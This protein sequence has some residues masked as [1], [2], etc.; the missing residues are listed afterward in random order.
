M[1]TEMDIQVTERNHEKIPFMPVSTGHTIEEKHSLVEYLDVSI[2]GKWVAV[3][4]LSVCGKVVTINGPAVPGFVPEKEGIVRVNNST[5]KWVI[6]PLA[7][8]Q[9]KVEYTIHVDPGGTLPAWLV[10]MFATQ[11]PMQ[12]FKN[13]KEQL[14]KPVSR[15]TALAFIE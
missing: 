14:K 6:T 2:N 15:G 9:I 13:L 3:P 1:Q 11:A 10:N 7:Q 8:N 5:G 4:A 12:M